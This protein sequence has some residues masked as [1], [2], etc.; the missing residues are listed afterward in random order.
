MAQLTGEASSIDYSDN[1]SG[2]RKKSVDLCHE[3]GHYDN[4]GDLDDCRSQN[5]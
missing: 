3:I 5:S 4:E 2:S 1:E